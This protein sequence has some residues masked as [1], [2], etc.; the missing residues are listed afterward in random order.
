MCTWPTFHS[1]WSSMMRNKLKIQMREYQ[2]TS[3]SRYPQIW[4]TLRTMTT[5][6]SNASLTQ[7]MSLQVKRMSW[8]TSS[9]W[10]QLKKSNL[11]W[12]SMKLHDRKGFKTCVCPSFSSCASTKAKTLVK[13][14]SLILS[15]RVLLQIIRMV[16]RSCM[17]R[18]SST[19][20]SVLWDKMH[21]LT[22][23][24]F[25]TM[26]LVCLQVCYLL[27]SLPMEVILDRKLSN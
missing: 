19:S 25:H 13:V 7:F 24:L 23:L 22:E 27:R 8:T 18:V 9:T 15:Y 6:P 3:S 1:S 20:S 5:R 10:W 21:T 4:S 26:W 16:T 14:P 17:N 2:T 11:V 12:S